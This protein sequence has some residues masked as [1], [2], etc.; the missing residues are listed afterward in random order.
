[1]NAP[2]VDGGDAFA[3]AKLMLDGD[4]ARAA[5]DEQELRAAHETQRQ[6]LDHQVQELHAAASDVRKGAWVEGSL[7]LAGGAFSTLG[8]LAASST[9]AASA[10]KPVAVVAGESLSALARPASALA[11][12]ASEKDAEARAKAH[13]A[14]AADAGERADEAG[15]HRDRLLGDEDR[16]LSTVQ[17]VLQDEAAGRLA[18]IANA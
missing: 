10:K 15:R 9:D 4:D 16:T 18:L 5:A 14:R 2:A 7:A 3:L 17:S 11:F 6:E 13:E 12:G 8:T 1:M